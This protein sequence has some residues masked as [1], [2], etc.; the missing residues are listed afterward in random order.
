MII[1]FQVFKNVREIQKS[2]S[3]EALDVWTPQ[4]GDDIF[5]KFLQMRGKFKN[6]LVQK[7]WTSGPLKKELNEK[8]ECLDVWTPQ[9]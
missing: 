3:K 1:F 9:N 5:F 7:L 4:K 8:T 6:S 2:F